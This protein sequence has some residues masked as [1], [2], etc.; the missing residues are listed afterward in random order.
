M[1]SKVPKSLWDASEFEATTKPKVGTT[2]DFKCPENTQLSD[3]NDGYHPFDDRFT[4]LC[5]TRKLYDTPKNWPKCVNFCPIRIPYVP[6]SKTGLI[7]VQAQNNI[8]KG[9][10]GRYVCQDTTL[11]VDRVIF[12][13]KIQINFFLKDTF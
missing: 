12:G 5:S 8:P 9:K 4:I 2:I 1:E 6:P 11:G 3:D 10:F 7:G 13:A